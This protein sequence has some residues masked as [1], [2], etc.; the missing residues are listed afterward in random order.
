M[1]PN[2]KSNS[3]NCVL[4]IWGLLEASGVDVDSIVEQVL[5]QIGASVRQRRGTLERDA[6]GSKKVKTYEET[7][8]DYSSCSY[9]GLFVF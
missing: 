2:F 8:L 6:C 1:E 7:S 3:G 9:S 4:I 5:T